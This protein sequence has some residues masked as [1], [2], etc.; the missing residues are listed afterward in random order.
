MTRNERKRAA[1]AKRNV[2]IMEADKAIALEAEKIMAR[3]AREQ[4]L[5]TYTV[6][7]R[8][9]PRGSDTVSRNRSGGVTT[10]GGVR[11]FVAKEPKVLEPLKKGT[12]ARK[13]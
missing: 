5:A 2:I 7:T 13:K 6:E 12:N 1:K 10:Q 9:S 8:W 3:N 11:K 4:F